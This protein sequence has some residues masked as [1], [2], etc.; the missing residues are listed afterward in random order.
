MKTRF[1]LAVLCALAVS[2]ATVA[3]P[4]RPAAVAPVP[5]PDVVHVAL[6]TEVGTIVIDLDHKNAPLTTENFMR[7]VDQKRLDGI[8]FYRVMRLAWGT[9]PNGLIQAG[10]R[11]DPRRVLKPVAHEPTSQ[12]GIL[13]KAGTIS[14]ARLAPGTATADFSILMADMPGLDAGANPADPAGYAAFGH[15]VEGMDV[16]RKIFDLPLDPVKGEG[17]MKGQFLAKELKIV[18]ARRVKIVASVATPRP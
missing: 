13:H 11:G 8:V 16:V 14:M 4:K 7:Y 1:L 5:L 18:S 17:F 10:A 3:A 15:V 2:P 12:T 9:Q 6:T